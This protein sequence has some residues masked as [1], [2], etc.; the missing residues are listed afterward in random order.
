M[1]DS[2]ATVPLAHSP[3]EEGAVGDPYRRHVHGVIEGAVERAE[4]MMGYAATTPSGLPDAVANAAIFHDLGKLDPD[5]QAVLKRHG[6]GRLKWD[7][8]DA[9]VAHA[10]TIDKMAAWLIRGHHAPG[11]PEKDE[12]FVDDGRR[13]RGR[14]HDDDRFTHEKHVEQMARTDAF[15]S[16]YLAEHKKQVNFPGSENAG[17]G[18]GL[19]MRL[20]LSCLV[21]ADH[22]DTAFF[23]SGHKPPDPPQ[24]RWDERLNALC[25]YIRSLPPGENEDERLRNKQRSEFFEACLNSDISEPMVACEGPVGLGKT[26]AVTAFLLQMAIQNQ[27]RRIIVVAP[28]TNIL[29][30]TAERLRKALVLPGERADHVVAEHH[31]RADFSDRNER[32][33]AALWRAPIVLTTAVSFFETLSS[34]SPTTL[35][36][37]HSVPGSAI[38]LDEAH[39]ALPTKLW[40]QNWKWLKQ[41]AEKWGCKIVFASGSLV[42]FWEHEDIVNDPMNLPE[43]MPAKQIDNVMENERRRIVYHLANEESAL[44]IQGLIELAKREPGPRLVILNTVKNAAIVAK[45]M[46]DEGMDVLHLSTALTPSDREI[47]LRRVERKLQFSDYDDW[48]LVATSCVEAGVDFSFFNAFRERFSAS[49]TI[50]TG[51]RVNRHGEYNEFGGGNVYDFALSDQGITKHP[52]A[53]ASADILLDFMKRDMLNTENPADIVTK[54]MRAELKDQGGLQSDPLVKAEKVKNYPKVQELGRVI[55]ADTRFVV[56]DPKVKAS[57]TKRE[58]V[59]F[60]SLMRGSIQLWSNAIDKLGLEPIYGRREIYFWNDVYDPDFLGYMSAVIRNEEI[61]SDDGAWIV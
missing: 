55:D 59:G 57:L 8:I 9:G 26:T 1:P 30:Q 6:G 33:L 27:L 32:E 24:C 39:A 15:L 42:R 40:P 41:L 61:M 38:F 47:I 13:L 28:F 22:S 25:E 54:S 20:A 21:D 50:Q 46:R 51:G 48:A 58:R 34:R 3:L 12:H 35:R 37:L 36:K 16:Q 19:T 23:D 43:L 29:T 31:H 17:G 56:I 52:A 2:Q 53:G 4:K 5:I 60:N 49:S 44:T 18:H 45:R 14:R 10:R 11:L 7:H